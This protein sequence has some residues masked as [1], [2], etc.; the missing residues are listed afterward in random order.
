MI[1]AAIKHFML[2]TPAIKGYTGRHI[3]SGRIPQE[4]T[5]TKSTVVVTIR[6]ITAT[7][8]D[9]LPGQDECVRPVLQIECYGKGPGA[10]IRTWNASEEIRKATAK[11]AYKGYMGT[12]DHRHFVHGVNIIRESTRLPVSPSDNSDSW[13]HRYSQDMQITHTQ[14]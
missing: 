8:F 11:I 6:K 5:P 3:Y 7:Q 1:E 14:A 12:G 4:V 9:D 2:N 13:T 10:D